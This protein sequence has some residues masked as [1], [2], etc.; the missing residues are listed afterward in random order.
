[1]STEQIDPALL[2]DKLKEVLSDENYDYAAAVVTYSET[3]SLDFNYTGMAEFRD[4][5]T[6]IKRAIYSDDEK[7][8]SEELTSAFEH[9]RR[10]AVESMQEY[11]E[12]KYAEIRRRI[13]LSKL[14]SIL[15]RYKKPKMKDIISSERIIKE[16]ISN[17][18]EAKPRKAWQEAIGYFKRAEDELDKLDEV[19]PTQ[20]ELDY[21]YSETVQTIILISFGIFIGIF[22]RS[23]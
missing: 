19:V 3:K 13:Y 9:I 2:I 16:N 18:R 17:G 1:M 11:V 10:A 21:R 8:S 15:A 23:M 4:A 20:E 6:H 12:V 5:L 14:K 7:K 22:L